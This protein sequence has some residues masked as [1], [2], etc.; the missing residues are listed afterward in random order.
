MLNFVG[1]YEEAT[2]LYDSIE[3]TTA[4]LRADQLGGS[5]LIRSLVQKSDHELPVTACYLDIIRTM[6]FADR[7]PNIGDR[8]VYL[9][10]QRARL[11]TFE[12][13]LTERRASGAGRRL[14]FGLRLREGATKA[15]LAGVGSGAC[16]C[17]GVSGAQIA[18]A[19]ATAAADRRNA[20]AGMSDLIKVPERPIR[21]LGRQRRTG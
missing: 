12:V 14:G 3:K 15:G 11:G 18:R 10:Y 6:D 16:G 7:S 1:R 19:V 2:K 5:F 8:V 9:T 4:G 21:T 20:K 17:I 13:E